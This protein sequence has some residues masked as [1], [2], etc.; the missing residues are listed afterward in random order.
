MQ[1]YNPSDG[2]FPNLAPSGAY[3]FVPDRFDQESHLYSEFS[4]IE[5]HQGKLAG[6]FA[7][8]Y[9]DS[10]RQA[11][12][13]A[14]VRLGEGQEP[15]EFEVQMLEI[16]NTDNK[17]CEVVAK[18]SFDG[19]DNQ[20]VFYTDSNGLEMQKRVRD[21]RPDYTLDT[22]MKVNDNYYPIN[23]AIAMRDTSKNLQVTVMNHHSQG[24]GVI[25]TGQ[26]ELM[27]NRRL[28]HDDWKG[29]DENLDETQ[30]DGRGI[31]VN[32]K[33]YVTFTDLNSQKSVQRS[34]QLR[35]DEPLQYFYTSNFSMNEAVT[36]EGVSAARES[37]AKLGNQLTDFDGELKLHQFALARN[38][39]L[40]RLENLADLY[41]GPAPEVTPTFD[42]QEYAM[43]L[44]SSANG[45]AAPASVSIVER[46]LSNNQ[47]MATMK[48]NKF[49]WTSED[50]ENPHLAQPYPE[51]PSETTVAL[52]PQRIRVFKVT[53]TH[54]AQEEIQILT[55]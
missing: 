8:V 44:Y 10:R 6:E 2:D 28:F 52:Q 37:L 51:D 21:F 3:L 38:E 27:Q 23:S 45:G 16:P 7:I 39:V 17:G 25:Q 26:I 15:I 49:K 20:D 4:S 14:L 19:I 24:G 34:T 18:W 1:Y 48:A 53:Y 9:A 5:V 54:A 36:N 41:D 29:V 22:K 47:D 30:P 50:G 42:L 32:T 11:V 35:T 13:Q 40:L 46:T 31:A 12:Y 55:E 43:A 33:Y